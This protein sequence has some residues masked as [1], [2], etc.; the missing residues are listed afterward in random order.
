MTLRDLFLRM[1][2]LAAPWRVER[3]LNDELAFGAPGR[4]QR[5]DTEPRVA[6]GHASFI[7]RPMAADMRSHSLASTAS[8][9]RP[10]AVRR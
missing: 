4:E 3:E 7:T 5:A 6:A 2:A 10:A 9:R 8:W 1:R